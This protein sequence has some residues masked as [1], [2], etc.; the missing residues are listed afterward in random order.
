MSS[1]GAL[2]EAA[3]RRAQRAD[4]SDGARR[5]GRAAAPAQRRCEERSGAGL[6]CIPASRSRVEVRGALDGA[7]PLVFEGMASVTGQFY[8]MW[9]WAGPYLEQVH[10][11]AFGETLAASPDVPLVLDHQSSARLARTGNPVSPLMLSEVTDGEVTGLHTLAPSLQ[12]D[13]PFVARIVPLLSSGLIDE[14]SFR[15]Q[16]TS[17]RWSDDWSEYHIHAVDIDRGDVSIVGFGAN[18]LTAGSGLRSLDR[19]AAR[20]VVRRD[21]TRMAQSRALTAADQATLTALLVQ[22]AAS[23]A[24]LDPICEALCAADDVLDVAAAT[25][26]GLLGLPNP[27]PEDMAMASSTTGIPR[28]LE[29][30]RLADALRH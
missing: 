14:M 17:G 18:P 3:E 28:A 2:V 27:D 13:N 4:S 6:Q 10:V 7:G 5:R 23:D 15:F 24:V 8:E 1:R 30:A 20:A 21:L 9:D 12:R 29:A 11:G 25:L 16:I 22:I 26:S 19:A